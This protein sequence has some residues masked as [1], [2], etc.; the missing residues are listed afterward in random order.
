MKKVQTH[1]QRG[2]MPK[3]MS[4]N[5]AI[6]CVPYRSGLEMGHVTVN[7]IETVCL[8]ENYSNCLNWDVYAEEQKQIVKVSV[9][10]RSLNSDHRQK[11]EESLQTKIALTPDGLSTIRRSNYY[12]EECMP[13]AQTPRLD[14]Y[15]D[16]SELTTFA[17]CNTACVEFLC[18]NN[19]EYC[20]L[21]LSLHHWCYSQ[22]PT[23]PP[24]T[25]KHGKT[26]VS[27]KNEKRCKIND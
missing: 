21:K 20:L 17:L 5:F 10:E 3:S 27:G 13:L 8:L 14:L 12:I 16:N 25:T 24:R 1:G 2:G 19:D 22:L 18:K 15:F 4:E 9:K 23:S 6:S 7:D 11:C 26:N